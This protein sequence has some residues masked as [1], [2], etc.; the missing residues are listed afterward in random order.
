MAEIDEPIEPANNAAPP[1]ASPSAPPT[2][3]ANTPPLNDPDSTVRSASQ[4][5]S[6]PQPQYFMDGRCNPCVERGPRSRCNKTWPSCSKCMAEGTTDWCFAGAADM[7]PD[8]PPDAGSVVRSHNRTEDSVDDPITP[9]RSPPPPH[10]SSPPHTPSLARSSTARLPSSLAPSRRSTTARSHSAE[11]RRSGSPVRILGLPRGTRT[12]SPSH[13]H[14]SQGTNPV[15]IDAEIARLERL[16]Q[17]RA[18]LG[19][20]DRGARAQGAIMTDGYARKSHLINAT[21]HHAHAPS[22]PASM[23]IHPH[24]VCDGRHHSICTP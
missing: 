23:R 6:P 18:E 20:A 8:D 17:L 22:T 2:D 1:P 21:A 19:L 12:R 16:R 15:D 10:D 14:A 11:P 24:R 5:P 4:P 13:S 9:R 3:H 7:A